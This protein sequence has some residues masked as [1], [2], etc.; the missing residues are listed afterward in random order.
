MTVVE[1]DL[2][3]FEGVRNAYNFMI[4]IHQGHEIEEVMKMV[5]QEMITARAIYNRTKADEEEC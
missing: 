4:L 2:G 1:Y 3:Y 5:E